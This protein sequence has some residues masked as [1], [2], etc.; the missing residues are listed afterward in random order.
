MTY[1][2]T[3]AELLGCWLAFELSDILFVPHHASCTAKDI[4]ILDRQDANSK[5]VLNTIGDIIPRGLA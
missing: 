5:R 1:Y 2:T 3:E 4:N